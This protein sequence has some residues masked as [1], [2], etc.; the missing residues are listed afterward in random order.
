MFRLQYIHEHQTQTDSH[1][2]SPPVSIFYS[3]HHL[4]IS[5][6]ALCDMDRKLLNSLRMGISTL[7]Q[8][9]AASCSYVFLVESITLLQSQRSYRDWFFLKL[10]D[11]TLGV[12]LKKLCN[13]GELWIIFSFTI[14][15]RNL[16]NK[17]S[18]CEDSSSK[19]MHGHIFLPL[20]G[21]ALWGNGRKQLEDYKI[22]WY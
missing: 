18:F 11:S 13:R 16:R 3:R 8:Y 10:V 17:N 4:S 6:Q 15:L 21:E 5:F 22:T 20:W 7:Y 9:N 2:H 19:Y 12:Q 14:Q 1:T